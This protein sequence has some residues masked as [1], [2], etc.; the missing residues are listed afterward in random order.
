M[1]KIFETFSEKDFFLNANLHIHSTYSDGEVEFDEL[2]NQA[3]RLKLKCFSITD[4]NTVE[5]YNNIDK[6]P[7][8]ML[9]GVEFD[10]YMDLNLPHILGYGVD[11]N[12]KELLALTTKFKSGKL[13]LPRRILTSRN[14]KKVIEAIHHAGGIAVLAHPCC[15]WCLNLD[16]FVKKLVGYG[17]DG[18]EVYYPY[19]RLTRV[20]KFH[21]RK[22]VFKLADRYNLIKTG[23][24]DQHKD[25]TNEVLYGNIH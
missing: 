7:E 1:R 13:E 11:I 6:I 18:I 9:T 20:V 23:G 5:G 2:I 25:I 4:H 24:Q 15:Y 21:S 8:E 10:C 12:N 14:P 3:K 17:L 16:K 19:D 22:T